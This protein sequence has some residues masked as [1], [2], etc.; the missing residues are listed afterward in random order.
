M[1]CDLICTLL[2]KI[3]KRYLRFLFFSISFI[4]LLFFLLN[5]DSRSRFPV[6]F[7]DIKILNI[8][9]FQFSSLILIGIIQI[10]VYAN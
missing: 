8:P 2:N 4:Y 10:V 9:N 3:L 1:C 6:H 7:F 5:L